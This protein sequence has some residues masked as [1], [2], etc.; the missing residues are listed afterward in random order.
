MADQLQLRGGTTNEHSTFTG[1]LREV[2]VDTDKDT[3]IVHDAATAGG[4]PLLREDGS[5]SAFSLGTAGTPSLKFTGDANTGIYSPGADQVAISTGGSGR[6][7]VASDGKTGVATSSPQRW[8]HVS[9]A[10]ANVARF[11]GTSGN[12][13]FIEYKGTAGTSYA[14]HSGNSFVIAPNSTE[15]LRITSDGKVGV[16]TSSPT[17]LFQCVGLGQFGTSGTAG[18]TLWAYNTSSTPNAG[19]IQA[20]NYGTGGSVF[21]GFDSAGNDKIRLLSNGG[22]YFDGNVG[23]GTTSPGTKFEVNAGHIR[24]STNY[25]IGIGGTGD[26]PSDAFVKFAT[27]ELQFFTNNSQKAAI[28]S[29]GRL[30]VGTSAAPSAG[31]PVNPLATFY[32]STPTLLVQNSQ[33]TTFAEGAAIHIG[34]AGANYYR[35]VKIA[36]INDEAY[37]NSLAFIVNNG[38]AGGKKEAGRFDYNG[39]LLVG[40]STSIPT[41][42][43]SGGEALQI[44]GTS[45]AT[46]GAA[47][48][49]ATDSGAS[50][51]FLMFARSRASDPSTP[52]ILQSGDDI[53]EIRFCGADG[54][55]YNSRAASIK[56]EVDGT[57]GASDM[58]GRLVFSTTAD[59]ASVP[60]ERMR[61]DSSGR[62]GIGTTSPSLPLDVIA[63]RG[64]LARFQ[65]SGSPYNGLLVITDST[66]VKLRSNASG[67]Y[68][69]FDTNG[70]ER[71]RIDSSGRLGLGTSTITEKLT[72]ICNND[73]SSID[74]GLGIY[75][76]VGDDKITINAQ[77][78]AARFVAD[79]GSNYMPYRITQYNGTTLR[80][81][82][83][84]DIDG[85]VGIGTT[86]PGTFGALLEV[87]GMGLFTADGGGDLIRFKNSRSSA[88]L[89]GYL[90]DVNQDKIELFAYDSSYSLSFGTNNTERARI[91]SSGRLLVGT[92]SWTNSYTTAVLQGNAGDGATGPGYLV[93]SR[94]LAPSS[95]SAGNAVGVIKFTANNAGTFA[96]I[97]TEADG[98]SGTDDYPGRLVFSTTADGASSPTERMRISANGNFAHFASGGTF[99]VRNTL[100]GTT[101]RV[102]QVSTGATSN[103]SGGTVRFLIAGD[104]DAENT[105]NRY[106]GISDQKLKE[107]IVDASSQWSD[108]KQL[109]VRNFNFKAETGYGTHTQIGLIAQEVEA[110]SPG[111]VKERPDV[112]S[113][114]NQLDTSTKSVAYSVL[115]MKAVKALQEAMERIETLE[116]K[117][118]ALEAQ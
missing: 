29:S 55:D 26:S 6:L 72:L 58:P 68:L 93:I 69:G 61:I 23:I 84:I 101:D 51:A 16:G 103:T 100:S 50:P 70:T 10:Q 104:G 86:S 91:D 113:E 74:N 59:G 33:T 63:A 24:L 76:S 25:R 56:C 111:L 41:G 20:R 114:G 32:G 12:D 44:A 54:V 19:T 42:G 49:R 4:H 95:F 80:E 21:V 81:T 112:D 13:A 53:A 78:G 22:A 7:F 62:V 107:N 46:G 87:N 15:R 39:R 57:P 106:T 66:G 48:I 115:Y 9:S 71:A 96:S 67:G 77:G 97:T 64:T 43:V 31:A 88:N 82:V 3:L 36:C 8:L 37:Q 28:D 98:A 92:S 116:A 73:T 85:N 117:V 38:D 110:V 17:S 94:G 1:A 102:F 27:N 47:I 45:G 75:R 18:T 60:T 34:G 90:S 35:G 109:T 83:H 79:G 65:E 118:A 99:N 89:T 108:I 2:T 52:T 11:E 30:L 40:T 14:G 105:N 5:N